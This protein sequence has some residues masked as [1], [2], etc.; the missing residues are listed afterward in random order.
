M[1]DF[2]PYYYTFMSDFSPYYHTFMRDFYGLC[3]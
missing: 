2:S 1:M 3:E